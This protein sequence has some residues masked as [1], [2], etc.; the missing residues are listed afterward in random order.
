M[1]APLR[2]VQ[3]VGPIGGMPATNG[4][5]GFS[6]YMCGVCAQGDPALWRCVLSSV[7]ES[8]PGPVD[9]SQAQ[10]WAL[11]AP[12]QVSATRSSAPCTKQGLQQH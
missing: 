10:A 6:L 8:V 4:F 7:Q 3:D 1:A 2:Q 11:E 12:P 5:I 9:Y